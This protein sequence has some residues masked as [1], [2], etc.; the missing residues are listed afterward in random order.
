MMPR[1]NRRAPRR[2]TGLTDAQEWELQISSPVTNF[3]SEKERERAWFANRDRLMIEIGPMAR[4]QGYW[5]YE[6]SKLPREKDFAAL[7]RLNLLTE[8]EARLARR[9]ASQG[10]ARYEL[11]EPTKT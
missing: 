2:T 11:D 6:Q 4:P 7:R 9:W 8:Q 3:S 5:E 1:I 10:D